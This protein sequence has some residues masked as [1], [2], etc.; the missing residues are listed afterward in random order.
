MGFP[1]YHEPAVNS[2]DEL[3]VATSGSHNLRRRSNGWRQ[4][5]D[6]GLSLPGV[7]RGECGTRGR[8]AVPLRRKALRA[9]GLRLVAQGPLSGAAAFP[10]VRVLAAPQTR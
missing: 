5:R 6:A 9:S 4:S 3:A 1:F 2:Q 7:P 10:A 8:Q